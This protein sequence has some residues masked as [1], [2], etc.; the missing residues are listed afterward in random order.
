MVNSPLKLDRLLNS[1]DSKDYVRIC[2]GAGIT[3][4]DVIFQIEA[5]LRSNHRR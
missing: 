1:K 2:K 5:Y 3:E 4:E